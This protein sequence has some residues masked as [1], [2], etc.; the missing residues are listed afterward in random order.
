MPIED[1]V[2]L[3]L[4]ESN[5]PEDLSYAAM[6]AHTLSLGKDSMQT[7]QKMKES[8]QWN[9]GISAD[10]I[11]Q[12][13]SAGQVSL[14]QVPTAWSDLFHLPVCNLLAALKAVETSYLHS[15]LL[16]GQCTDI[17]PSCAGAWLTCFASQALPWASLT[18]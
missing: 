6:F 7:P 17:L 8:L 10:P 12:P 9:S 11:V 14:Q 18:A 3:G 4:L 15:V 1:E 16:V 13:P 5:E 2:D